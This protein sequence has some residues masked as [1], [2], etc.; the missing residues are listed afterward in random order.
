[1]AQNHG[2]RRIMNRGSAIIDQSQWLEGQGWSFRGTTHPVLAGIAA[3]LERSMPANNNYPWFRSLKGGRAQPAAGKSIKRVI[4]SFIRILVH[5]KFTWFF[6]KPLIGIAN[7]IQCQWDRLASNQIAN[8]RI[9]M[10]ALGE[11]VVKNGPFK[12]M[13]YPDF[14]YPNNFSKIIGSYEKEIS[15]IIE[16]LCHRQF[17]EILNIGCG[18]EYYPIGFAR[19][20]ENA[21]IIAYDNREIARRHC[22]EMARLNQVDKKIRILGSF[23]KDS[24]SNMN[25]DRRVLILC[26]CEGGEKEIFTLENASRLRSCELPIEIHDF[27]DITISSY[28]RNLFSETHDILAIQSTD[29]IYKARNYHF[30]ETDHLDLHLKKLILE[31]C[32]PAP[33]EWF[34]I[35]PKSLRR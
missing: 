23:T 14:L 10:E 32:R 28:V 15:E 27:I 11:P 21:I 16:S 5:N 17:T 4:R 25:L 26:D 6:I 7:Y 9:I 18:E 33:M 34:Y 20:I 30:R 22:G 8:Q 3:I 2:E 35:T 12:G 24:L 1:M 19:R 13:I 29:D 31:E